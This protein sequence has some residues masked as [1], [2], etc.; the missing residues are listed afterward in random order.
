MSNSQTSVPIAADTPKAPDAT[1]LAPQQEQGKPADDK[2]NEHRSK[3]SYSMRRD[4]L[5]AFY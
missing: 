1:K 2:P 3:N 5:A 4:H